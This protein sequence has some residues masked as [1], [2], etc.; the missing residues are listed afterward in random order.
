MCEFIKKI[1]SCAGSRYILNVN[2]EKLQTIF[3]L[4]GNNFLLMEVGLSYYFTS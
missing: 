2:K 3:I 4:S 1:F